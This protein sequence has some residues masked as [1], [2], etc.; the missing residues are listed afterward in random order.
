MQRGWWGTVPWRWQ[1]LGTSALGQQAVAGAG[2]SQSR[3]PCASQTTDI[4]PSTRRWRR[5]SLTR[6]CLCHRAPRSVPGGPCRVPGGTPGWAHGSAGR[7]GCARAPCLAGESQTRPVSRGIGSAGGWHRNGGRLQYITRP[8]FYLPCF[9][10]LPCKS[11]S[12]V[13]LFPPFF[14]S[15]LFHYEIF[16]RRLARLPRRHSPACVPRRIRSHPRRGRAAGRQPAPR[17]GSPGDAV[18]SRRG[19]GDIWGTCRTEVMGLIP[20]WRH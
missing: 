18:P 8:G 16:T 5:R 2:S 14:F 12:V 3:A 11:V 20:M 17:P 9:E 6:G 4:R 10:P 15:P 19:G 7:A 13:T 1:S